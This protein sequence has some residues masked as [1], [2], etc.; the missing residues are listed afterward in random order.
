MGTF[1]THG[2]TKKD[3]IAEI[4]EGSEQ[5]TVLHHSVRGNVLWTVEHLKRGDRKIIGCYLLRSNDREWGYKPL[6][7]ECGPFYYSC[8]LK[9]LDLVPE[10]SAE[11]RA[12]VRLFHEQERAKRAAARVR[13]KA[14][15]KILPTLPINIL[16]P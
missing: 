11:W 3:I 14:I 4:L 9:F 8:P 6:S 7:E 1:Y 2:A 15:A 10:R 16:F 13:K 5:V 12:N